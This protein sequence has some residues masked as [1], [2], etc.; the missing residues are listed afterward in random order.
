MKHIAHH[1]V[2]TYECDSYSHV[3]NAVYLNYLEYGRREFLSAIGFDYQGLLQAGYYIYITHIDIHYRASAVLDDK[4]LIEVE[5]IA[6]K[7]VSGTFRQRVVKEDGT[8][9]A[10]AEVT[11]ACVTKNA[12]PHP[13]PEDLL[14]PGLSPLYS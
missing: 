9:C 6:L 2:R 10:D 3:N 5:P 7:K 13:I 8:V 11:W 14:V 4:L 12:I 1:T